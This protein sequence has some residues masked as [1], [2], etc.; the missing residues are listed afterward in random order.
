MGNSISNHKK[1]RTV[2]RDRLAAGDIP[3]YDKVV[4]EFRTPLFYDVKGNKHSIRLVDPFN[5]DTMYEEIIKILG[6]K[7]E[8]VTHIGIYYYAHN[9][10]RIDLTDEE[11]MKSLKILMHELQTKIPIIFIELVLRSDSNI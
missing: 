11:D 4:V 5:F 10:G 1:L 3:D 6:D 7:M 2:L 8:K 9:G